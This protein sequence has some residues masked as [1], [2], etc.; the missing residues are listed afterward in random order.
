MHFFSQSVL[1]TDVTSSSDF[2]RANRRRVAGI[3]LR[4][5]HA[6]KQS[7]KYSEEYRQTPEESY[8]QDIDIRAKARST[9]REIFSFSAAKSSGLGKNL[10][11]KR[12][13]PGGR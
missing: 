1:S 12:G 5:Q 4:P 9:L 3:S 6:A 11:G 7:K 10:G 13:T 2:I 8:E